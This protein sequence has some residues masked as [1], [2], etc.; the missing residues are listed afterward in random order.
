MPTLVVAVQQQDC[1]L[2][3][4]VDED[5]EED[6]AFVREMSR[7]LIPEHAGDLICMVADAKLV[8][9]TAQRLE[10]LGSNQVDP[11]LGEDVLDGCVEGDELEVP[12]VIGEALERNGSV[13]RLEGA[14]RPWAAWMWHFMLARL[15]LS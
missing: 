2:P 10:P 8:K 5:P 14:G 9:A 1:S 15:S 3:V 4:E 13:L 6:P 12:E 7:L 11:S